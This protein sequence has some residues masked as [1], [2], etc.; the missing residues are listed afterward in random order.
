MQDINAAGGY[1]VNPE[2]QESCQSSSTATSDAVLAG[3]FH[4]YYDLH[5]ENAGILCG[6]IIFNVLSRVRALLTMSHANFVC[7]NPVSVHFLADSPT[8]EGLEGLKIEARELGRFFAR[9]VY[10][11]ASI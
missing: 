2:A 10:R 3:R 11:S 7:K 9:S 4:I 6:F 5:W 8:R 1:L